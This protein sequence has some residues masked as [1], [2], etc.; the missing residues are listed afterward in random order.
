[1]RKILYCLFLPFYFIYLFIL[2]LMGIIK[3]DNEEL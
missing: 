2:T 3:E 1:M